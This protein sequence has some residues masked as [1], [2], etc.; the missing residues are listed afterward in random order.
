MAGLTIPL[1]NTHPLTSVDFAGQSSR[2]CDNAEIVLMRPDSIIAD[3]RDAAG[4]QA[5]DET[6]RLS[7]MLPIAS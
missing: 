7:S 5:G 6:A 1:N 3:H 2:P 4:V